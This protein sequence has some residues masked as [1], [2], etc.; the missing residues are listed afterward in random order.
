MF[1]N[2][3]LGENNFFCYFQ[4]QFLRLLMVKHEDPDKVLLELTSADLYLKYNYSGT[5]GKRPM[6]DMILFDTLFFGKFWRFFVFNQ[7]FIL[8]DEIFNIILSQKHVSRT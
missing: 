3:K 6:K 8:T 2:D 7:K 5:A 1:F 4:K